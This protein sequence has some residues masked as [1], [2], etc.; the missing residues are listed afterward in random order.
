MIPR[1]IQFLSVRTFIVAGILFVA[2]APPTLSGKSSEQEQ[3]EKSLQD[4]YN[5]RTLSLRNFYIGPRLEF[6]SQGV[7]LKNPRVGPWT[8]YCRVLV[9]SV[10]L[11]SRVLEIDGDRLFLHY[12][13]D[14]KEFQALRDGGLQIR[15][16]LDH[17]PSTTQDLESLLAKIFVRPEENFLTLVPPYWK[18][19]CAHMNDPDWSKREMERV[20]TEGKGIAEGLKQPFPLHKPDPAYSSEAR[21]AKISGSLVLAVAIDQDGHV[22]NIAVIRPLGMGLDE[23]AVQTIRTW[24]F[25]PAQVNGQARAAKTMVEVSFRLF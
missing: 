4:T 6:D 8:L 16:D 2:A 21:K 15:I 11:K 25:K 17:E 5:G 7:A 20:S 24:T 22:M 14:K 23:N 18:E 19:F 12:I 13:A 1:L 3:I 9:N 10:K